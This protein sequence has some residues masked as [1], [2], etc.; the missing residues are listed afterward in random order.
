M[1]TKDTDVISVRI[2]DMQFTMIWVVKNVGRLILKSPLSNTQPGESAKTQIRS[3]CFSTPI[4][5][6]LP[7]SL[8]Q[9]PESFEWPPICLLPPPPSS[10]YLLPFP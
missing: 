1:N 6:G 9:K 10:L 8:E 4:P 2:I 3:C 7:S 5:P